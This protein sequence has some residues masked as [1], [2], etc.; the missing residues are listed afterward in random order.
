MSL[1]GNEQVI[2]RRDD[3]PPRRPPIA[4]DLR[5]PGRDSARLAGFDAAR[6]AT[7]VFILLSP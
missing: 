2:A 1:V 4:A 5:W 7:V 3:M 6:L